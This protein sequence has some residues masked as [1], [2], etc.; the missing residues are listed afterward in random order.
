MH[1]AAAPG[2][3]RNAF[4]SQPAPPICGCVY[5]ACR[6]IVKLADILGH[7]NIETTLIYL[8]TTGEKHAQ[9]LDR[10]KLIG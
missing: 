1:C 10:L 9:L 7:S 5:H 8:V 6:D 2:W 3:T 4:P